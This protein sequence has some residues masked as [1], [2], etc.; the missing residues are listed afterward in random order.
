GQTVRFSAGGTTFTG[1]LVPD[2]PYTIVGV[3]PAGFRF[4]M[5]NAQFWFPRKV[6]APANM[7]PGARASREAIA[8]LAPGATPEA[9][10]AEMAS[11]RAEARGTS[12]SPG[13]PRYALLRL[14]DEPASPDRP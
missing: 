6:V 11:M 9:A 13:K 3:M 7:P 10:A 2:L 1:G 5:D 12:V 4:P 14:Y 8:R